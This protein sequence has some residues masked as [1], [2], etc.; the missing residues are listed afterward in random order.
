MIGF[1]SSA[2]VIDFGNGQPNQNVILAYARNSARNL[3][4][5]VYY[6]SL[7]TDV[8]GQFQVTN[9]NVTANNWFHVAATLHANNTA[10]LYFNGTLVANSTWTN[11][12]INSL[13]RTK[14]YVGKS[15]FASDGTANAR[16]R[17]LR[18][19]TK[20]LSQNDVIDDMFN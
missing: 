2:R 12:S 3:F 7:S 15:N 13:W 6:G 19:Y 11:N 17:N 4:Y 18:F 8:K 9:F 14:N 16:F 10:C 5:K 1:T 20:A